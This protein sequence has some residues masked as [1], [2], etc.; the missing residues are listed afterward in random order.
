MAKAGYPNGFKAR[1]WTNDKSVRKDT[2]VILQDQLKQIGIDVQIEILE[3]GSYLDRVAKGEHDMF[4]L[5]WSSSADSDSAMYALFHSKNLGGAGNRTFYKNPKVDELLDKARESTVPEER[6]KYYKEIQDI[7]QEEL[8]MFALVYPD[9]IT[10]M[11]KNIEGFVFHP[12]GT[13]Y[14]A[15]VTK[16]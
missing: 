6:I 12:E 1:I 16:K 13:H 8:P 14:L 9:E 10:G 4:I 11:Q 5:G 3:W 2:A 7:I 15:P